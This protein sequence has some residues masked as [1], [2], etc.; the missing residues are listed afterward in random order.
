VIQKLLINISQ[1][2][3]TELAGLITQPDNQ[4]VVLPLSET[5]PQSLPLI[6][7]YPS[8]LEINQNFKQSSSSQPTLQQLHQEI[9]NPQPNLIYQLAQTPI[10]GSILCHLV[11]EKQQNLLQEDTDFNIDYQQRTISFKETLAKVDKIKLDY[12]FISVCIIREFIQEF[13]VDIID[14]N[15][16]NIEKFSSLISGIILTNNDELIADYNSHFQ[17]NPYQSKQIIA[18]STI[19]YIHFLNANYI[20]LT[21]P[22][23]FQLKLQ[24]KGQLNLSRTVRES[25]SPIQTIKLYS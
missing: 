1:L 24:V 10:K 11:I 5:Q 3:Q 8:K 17:A 22:L 16:E 25:I 2:L 19:S 15:L 23:K 7:I 18:N 14:S 21:N 12:S 9:D 6:G 20:N 13:F 4:I